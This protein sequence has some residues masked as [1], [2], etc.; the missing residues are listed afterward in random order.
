MNKEMEIFVDG[1][2]NKE[3]MLKYLLVGIENVV[4]DKKL[5][6]EWKKIS[7]NAIEKCND[8]C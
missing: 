8:E 5:I 6:D 4:D 7:E 1:K 2:V 3:N